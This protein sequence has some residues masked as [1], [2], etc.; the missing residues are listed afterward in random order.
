MTHLGLKSRQAGRPA[1]R[2]IT[3]SRFN[4]QMRM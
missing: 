4:V 1:R 2:L 3:L